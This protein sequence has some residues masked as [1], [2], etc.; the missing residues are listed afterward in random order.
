MPARKSIYRVA[1]EFWRHRQRFSALPR[2][3][4][5]AIVAG[6]VRGL[7]AEAEILGLLDPRLL[8]AFEADVVEVIERTIT[9]GLGEARDLVGMAVAEKVFGDR[10]YLN[11]LDRQLATGAAAVGEA[12]VEEALAV[13]AA[14]VSL[15]IF[16][17]RRTPKPVW[18]RSVD[19]DCPKADGDFGPDGEVEDHELGCNVVDQ[20]VEM[21]R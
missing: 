21:D 10:I 4:D 6:E 12:V 20:C 13:V 2:K 1:A 17:E 7:V 16:A 5:G 11:R 14:A 8:D 9:E 19:V 3:W 18:P 15:R